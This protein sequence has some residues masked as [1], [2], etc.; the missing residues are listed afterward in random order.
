MI[1]EKRFHSSQRKLNFLR[2]LVEI[3]RSGSQMLMASLAEGWLVRL[4][5]ALRLTPKP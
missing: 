1:T 3:Y 5:R 4:T 2:P